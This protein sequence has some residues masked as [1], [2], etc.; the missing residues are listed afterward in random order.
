M[1]GYCSIGMLLMA[2]SPSTTIMMAM[3]MANIGR[4]TKKFPIV[5][6]FWSE[7]ATVIGSTTAPS[8]TLWK[9]EVTTRAPESS[10]ELTTHIL[11]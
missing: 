8:R 3:T 10:P 7:S 4:L 9:P 1:S 6:Y 5:F 11:L 2:I